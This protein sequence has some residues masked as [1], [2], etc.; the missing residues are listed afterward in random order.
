M[1]IQPGG[2][3]FQ[4]WEFGNVVLERQDDDP[5]PVVFGAET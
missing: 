1:I 3:M 2:S 4:Q 5:I